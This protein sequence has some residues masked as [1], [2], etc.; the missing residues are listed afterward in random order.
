MNAVVIDTNVL[1]VANNNAPQAG[2]ECVLAVV[3]RLEQVQSSE[4]VCLDSTRFILSEYLQQRLSFSGQPGMGDAFFK[5][6]FN[7]QANP[8][9]CE[10]V[11]VHPRNS[12]G[13][14][15]DEFPSDPAL[16]AFDPSDR[17][18]V[19]V[20]R[21]SA[22]NPPVLNAVDSDWWIHRDSLAKHNVRVEFLC[23]QQ[24]SDA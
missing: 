6:L 21:A 10:V 7:N 22:S 1:Y 23:P 16:A 3:R 20:A 14:D 15:F 17:K 24:F 2:C 13:T 11:Q 12:D 9:H 18:F 5:W 4:R 8:G 19:A